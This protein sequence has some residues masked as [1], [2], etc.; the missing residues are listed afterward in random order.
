MPSRPPFRHPTKVLL[1]DDEALVASAVRA[2]LADLPDL[3]FHFCQDSRQ[4]LTEARRLGPTV[5]LQD[6]LMP[7]VDGLE[8][9]R[10]YRQDEV[11]RG[12]PV[13]VV[14]AK[15]DARSKALAF[16]LGASDYLVK[17]PNKVELVA[18]VKHHSGACVSRRQRDEAFEALRESE[19]E[20]AAR[21]GELVALNARLE[22]ATRA[23]SEF[24][25]NMSHEIRTPMNGVIGM[26]ALLLETPLTADQRT[27]VDTIRSCGE[28]LLTII[29][30]ILD[31]S[32]IEAGRVEVEQHPYDLRQCVE[33]AC[34][35]VAPRAAEKGLDLVVLIAP[36]T[37]ETVIGDGTRLRQILVNLAVNAVKFTPRGQVVVE[38]RAE[39]GPAP[40]GATLRFAVHDTGIGVPADKRDRLFRSF[41]QVDSSTTRQY[42]GT[43]LGL[44][45]CKRLA[46]LLGGG[47]GFDSDEGKGSTFSFH[48]QVRLGEPQRPIWQTATD[49]LRGR[50][51][52][53]VDDNAAQ[54]RLVRECAGIW[55]AEV[56]EAATV[57]EAAGL[58]APAGGRAPDAVV[59]D[60]ELLGA[61]PAAGLARLRAGAAAVPP[62]L[63]SLARHPRAGE[64]GA[65]GSEVFLVRPVRPAVLYECLLQLLAERALPAGAT[66]AASRP[67]RPLAAQLPLRVLVADDNTVNQMVVVMMLNRMG[68]AADVV[69]NG[70]EVLRALEVKVYDLIFLDIRMP[71]LDGYDVARRVRERWATQ[72]AGRPRLVAITG[73]A[74]QGERE[75]CLEAGMDDYVAKPFRLDDLRVMLQRW[76]RRPVPGKA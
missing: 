8:L 6:L 48:V 10:R 73:N 30:D 71:E 52:L 27:C 43:G 63:L 56:V 37:P 54:R 62:L 3:E 70:L 75:R 39:P 28:S 15:E 46:E 1:V 68:Y 60:G 59:I 33:D 21:N 57:E 5:I 17:L 66:G 50:R 72:P 74:M 42:G 58:L 20:L 38:A 64:P 4:A 7:E 35:L 69:A 19:Q 44:A 61:D 22:E 23:K 25:A 32:K 11:L 47:I 18:R 12:V 49:G 40:G 65:G 9:L 51:I 55:Q 45:I 13:I 14:S 36:G 16:E 31:F 53:V 76:G 2:A 26:T 29:N 67:P 34:E 24:L 41:S